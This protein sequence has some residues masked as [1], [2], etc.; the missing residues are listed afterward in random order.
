[1]NPLRAI[2]AVDKVLAAVEAEAGLPRPLVVAETRAALEELRR[3]L[4]EQ[5]AGTPPPSFEAVVAGVRERLATL[6]RQRLRPVINATGVVL[7]TNLGRAPLGPEARQALAEAAGYSNLELDLATGR[8]GGRGAYVERCLALLCEAGAAT[9]VNNCAA[10][11]VL[12]LRHLARPPRHEVIVGRGELVQIG[13]GFRIPE[14]L[15]ASG[16]VL[17]EVGTTNRT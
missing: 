3:S 2:P 11:L 6:R 12:V 4:A 9:V 16:A 15:E 5:P 14:I 7:H 1:M 13:G 8:R 10:A 17:R